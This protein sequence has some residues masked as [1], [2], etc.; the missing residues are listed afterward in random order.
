MLSSERVDEEIIHRIFKT[1]LSDLSVRQV[2]KNKNNFTQKK[3]YVFESFVVKREE[4]AS[5][6]LD[7]HCLAKSSQIISILSLMRVI[8]TKEQS[9]SNSIPASQREASAIELQ[10]VNL[11]I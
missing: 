3:S 9:I 6:R 11:V 1:K 5:Y 10:H 2:E 4:Q 8:F 7:A